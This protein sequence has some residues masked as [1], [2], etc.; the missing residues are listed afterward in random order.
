MSDLLPSVNQ[1]LT[2]S[3]V[4]A[5]PVATATTVTRRK[6]KWGGPALWIPLG[7]L[8]LVAFGAIF[9][10]ILPLQDP[11]AQDYSQLSLRPF[12]HGHILGTDD[13]GRDIFSRIVHGARVSL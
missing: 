7:W 5:A 13:I 8:L 6:H 10:D 4:D 9:A 12:S 2:E 3:A 11:N 1:P